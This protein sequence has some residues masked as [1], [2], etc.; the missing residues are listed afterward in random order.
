MPGRRRSRH[1]TRASTR[2]I[3][4]ST[5]NR[6]LIGR[7]A[8]T[9]RSSSAITGSTRTAAATARPAAARS[10]RACGRASPACPARP[11]SAI[12]PARRNVAH[13]AGLPFVLAYVPQTRLILAPWPGPTPVPAGARPKTAPRT[14]STSPCARP[15]ATGSMR[16]SEVDGAP[17]PLRTTV[18]VEH[19][20]TIIT[21]NQSPDIGF[22]RSI[23]AYRGC[24][25]GCIYCFARPTHAFHDLSPGLDF[26][27]R[28]VRQAR[29]REAASRRAGEAGLPGPPDRDGHQHRSLPADRGQVA[30]HALACSKCSPRPAIR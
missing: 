11:R 17:P 23:N 16:A 9:C 19:P 10:P 5:S 29:R 15:T 13:G 7:R 24:E 6:C 21:R 3:P 1:G 8:A 20:K 28:A 18:T 12:E 4:C 30:D 2:A 25:H 22:D 26:E 14:A 27:S